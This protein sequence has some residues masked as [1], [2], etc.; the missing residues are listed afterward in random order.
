MIKS[1]LQYKLKATNAHGI[2]SPFVFEFYNEV[3]MAS[4]NDAFP[5]IEKLRKALLTNESRI[6]IKDFGAGSRTN[7]SNDRSVKEMTKNAS[8]DKKH[9]QLLAKIIE[10]YD[11]QEILELG[12]SLGLG[13][14]YLASNAKHLTTIEGDRT[15]HELAVNNFEELNLNNITAV[16]STFDEFLEQQSQDQLSK[17]DLVYIDGNHSYEATMNYFNQFADAVNNDAFLVFDDI[18]WSSGMEKA[19][20]EIQASEKINVSIELMRMGIVVK[21]KEQ[22]KQHFI[23]RF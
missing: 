6:E 9:G 13:S 16:C 14:A 2:H 5:S 15:T 21:R 12:T 20:Q 17:F 18:R 3:L 4:K 23:L 22:E 1:I 8:I 11:V 10:H 7:T 19:W